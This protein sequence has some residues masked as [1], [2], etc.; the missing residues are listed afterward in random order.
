MSLTISVL[1]KKEVINCENVKLIQCHYLSNCIQIFAHGF[2]SSSMEFHCKGSFQL[3]NNSLYM[4]K[5]EHIT[6]EPC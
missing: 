2:D 1:R 5:A 6:E 4:E 3:L